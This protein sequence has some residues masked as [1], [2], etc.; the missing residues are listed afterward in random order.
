M[1]GTHLIFVYGTL[2]KGRTNHFFLEGCDFKGTYFTTNDVTLVHCALPFLV[3]RKGQ[4]CK[5][6]VYEI[7]DSILRSIDY[8]EQHPNFYRREHIWVTQEDTGEQIKAWA[9]IHPDIFQGDFN[10]KYEIITNY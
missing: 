5:G 9:Y 4:G 3:K 10:R 1:A 7:D 6:E 2:K 8:L